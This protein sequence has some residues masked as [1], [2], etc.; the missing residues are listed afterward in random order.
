MKYLLVIYDKPDTRELFMSDEG[1]PLME[2]MMALMD[3][4]R[5]SGEMV[6][7]EGLADPSQTKTVKPENGV[8]VVTDGPLAEAKEH[9]GGFLL[10]DVENIERAVEIAKRFPG[11]RMNPVEVRPLMSEGGAEMDT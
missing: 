7:T 3:E 4:L 2:E 11:A 8:P 9:F 6:M 1:K 5:Q 10:I